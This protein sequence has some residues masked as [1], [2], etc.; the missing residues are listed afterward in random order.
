MFGRSIIQ[1]TLNRY[2]VDQTTLS[3]V[4]K[5]IVILREGSMSISI[6]VIDLSPFRKVLLIT[7]MVAEAVASAWEKLVFLS[8]RGT[9]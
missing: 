3:M 6:P 8:L 1:G 9:V 2:L 4:L 5:N 7:K